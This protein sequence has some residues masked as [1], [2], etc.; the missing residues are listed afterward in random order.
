MIHEVLFA[1]GTKLT[2]VH[3]AAHG[4]ERLSPSMRNTPV[5]VLHGMEY[6]PGEVINGHPAR[7]IAETLAAGHGLSEDPLVKQF[8]ATPATP[9]APTSAPTSAPASA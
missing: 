8:L 7:K 4:A 9:V 1:D 5:Y 3:S 6:G 2:N